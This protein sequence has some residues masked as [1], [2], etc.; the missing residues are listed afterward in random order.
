MHV[1]WKNI[2]SSDMN[3]QKNTADQALDHLTELRHTNRYYL[4][5]KMKTY[6]ISDFKYNN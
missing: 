2:N 5:F 6:K 1:V 3:Q 4:Y